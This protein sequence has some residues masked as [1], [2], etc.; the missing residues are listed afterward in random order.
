MEDRDEVRDEERLVKFV[1]VLQELTTRDGRRIAQLQFANE[2]INKADVIL[3]LDAW[4]RKVK[5]DYDSN[6]TSSNFFEL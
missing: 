4:L 1:F 2:G 5:E 6:A 3:I